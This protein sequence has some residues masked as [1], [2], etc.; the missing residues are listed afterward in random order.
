M[1]TAGRSRKGAADRATRWKQ[2]IGPA[3][4]WLGGVQYN[5]TRI[6]GICI[7]AGHRATPVHDDCSD[8]VHAADRRSNLTCG[9]WF[10]RSRPA[11]ATCAAP[12][13]ASPEASS[14]SV[15]R[16]RTQPPRFTC[17]D[18]QPITGGSLVRRR[19][20]RHNG[21]MTTRLVFLVPGFFGFTSVGAV[22][23][24]EDVEQALGRALRRR[25]VDARIVRCATQPTASI[26]RRADAL[27]R[28]V[29]RSGGL[30]ARELHFIG[31]ST[32]G[33]DVR[34]L[35]TPGAA[36]RARRH[37]GAHCPAD[38][39]G[40]FRGDA[41]PRDA[42]R[43]SLPHGPGPHAAAGAE[44]AGHVG[45]GA[46]RDSRGGE[47]HCAGGAAG[48][49]AGAPGNPARS[50][51][52]EPAAQDPVRSQGPGVEI[53][54]RDRARPGRGAAA[55]ARGHRPVRRGR[56][57]P[58]R[59]RLQLRRRR[60]PEAARDDSPQGAGGPRVPRAAIVVQAAARAHGAAAPALSVSQAG[61]GDAAA[62][63]S[64]PRLRGRRRA[65]ATASCR[66]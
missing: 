46:R 42:A 39:D 21:A 15:P 59:H 28:Q 65:S 24:F 33:L 20:R 55:H 1:A 64:R 51:R 16:S 6:A 25:G 10:E 31:H 12:V 18:N 37:R 45:A 34:M 43:Q 66:R 13:A 38:A 35:L 5:P 36:G 48:R 40:H 26:T 52:R 61:P 50:H 27:R 17:L 54:G 53:P 57:G 30:R 14:T 49:L 29:L 9:H 7:D 2:R 47:G 22:S 58:R 3:C 44:R 63:R 4:C 56:R 8:S 23:Y 32:G 11:G 19:A 60:R 41:A 62:A